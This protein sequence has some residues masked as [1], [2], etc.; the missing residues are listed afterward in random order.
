MCNDPAA[1]QRRYR[2]RNRPPSLRHRR[3]LIVSARVAQVRTERLSHGLSNRAPSS[4]I[5]AHARHAA[6]ASESPRRRIIVRA[7][8]RRHR[9][10]P[11]PR[12]ASRPRSRSPSSRPVPRRTSRAMRRDDDAVRGRSR[13]RSHR[14][15]CAAARPRAR[16]RAGRTRRERARARD[17]ALDAPRDAARRLATQMRAAHRPRHWDARGV[18]DGGM[19]ARTT[20]RAAMPARG[21]RRRSRARRR[22][23][24]DGRCRAAAGRRDACGRGRRARARDVVARGRGENVDGEVVDETATAGRCPRACSNGRT[25]WRR[26]SRRPRRDEA[27]GLRETRRRR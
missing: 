8:R 18:D 11:S 6:G 1:D 2:R 20:V 3:E 16:E 19:R 25:S 23:D 9:R 7:S 21:R 15:R 17:G 24:V 4:R 27:T 14:A 26:L 5:R 10:R 12:P 22:V 13:A